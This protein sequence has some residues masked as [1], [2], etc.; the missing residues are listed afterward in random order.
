MKIVLCLL[1]GLVLLLAV[2]ESL[3][4]WSLPPKRK[5]RTHAGITQEKA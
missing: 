4:R 2:L 1:L 5:E 3:A